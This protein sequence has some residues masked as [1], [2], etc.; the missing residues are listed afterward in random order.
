MGM[1]L[2]AHFSKQS[3]ICAQCEKIQLYVNGFHHMAQNKIIPSTLLHTRHATYN[4]TATVVMGVGIKKW[5]H[6]K[7]FCMSACIWCCEHRCFCVDIL[8]QQICQ[9]Q[10]SFIYIMSAQ[11]SW[12]VVTFNLAVKSKKY[13]QYFWN[14]WNI[15]L[16][17]QMVRF[18][19]YCLIKIGLF[20]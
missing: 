4:I 17:V 2:S 12:C 18:V 14:I 1:L 15:Y 5:H 7:L 10:C 9:Y 13:W 16:N 11:Q 8:L 3:N 6:V 20:F 19:L